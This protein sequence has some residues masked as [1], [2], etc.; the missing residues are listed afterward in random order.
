MR[1]M[2][3]QLSDEDNRRLAEVRKRIRATTDVEVFRK[4]LRLMEIL[5]D[6]HEE[7]KRIAVVPEYRHDPWPDTDVMAKLADAADVLLHRMDYDG[8]GW[9]EV[10]HCMEVAK[11]RLAD[12]QREEIIKI[13]FE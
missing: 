9:E 11:E 13:V 12:P 6:Y 5:L 10:Q 4:G 3:L 2:S 8:H 7:G 1:R